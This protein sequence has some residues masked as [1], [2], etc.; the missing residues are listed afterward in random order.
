MR[1]RSNTLWRYIEMNRF[2]EKM[3][4]MQ[5]LES[6]QM[7]SVTLLE[8]V[9]SVEGTD[10]NDVVSFSVDSTIPETPALVVSL[11]GVATSNPLASVTSIKVDVG[12]GNDSV[13]FGDVAIAGTVDGGDGK[14]MLSAGAGG[15]V[16]N[17]GGGKEVLGG[18]GRKDPPTGGDG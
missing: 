6:R 10:G 2:E 12:A 17:G 3:P 7:L 16:L 9:L 13:T 14:D 18:D 5:S 11:N 15:D 8:G 4:M 1:G